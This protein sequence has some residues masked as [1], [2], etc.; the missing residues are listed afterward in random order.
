MPV[1]DVISWTTMMT[2]Y[3]PPFPPQSIIIFDKGL[4]Y[5]LYNQPTNTLALYRRMVNEGCLPNEFT[6][7]CLLIAC[8]ELKDLEMGKHLHEQLS[9]NLKWLEFDAIH[10]ALVTMY[11]TCGEVLTAEKVSFL[12]FRS[13]SFINIIDLVNISKDRI[14]KNPRSIAGWNSLIN[15]YCKTNQL[16]AAIS[17]L[18][19]I[20]RHRCTPNANTF[21][22]LFKSCADSQNLAVA[23]ESYE[24]FKNYRIPHSEFTATSA[25]SMFSKCKS[26]VNAEAVS[27]GFFFFFFSLQKTITHSCNYIH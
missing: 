18:N 2:T 22:P 26:I 11:L 6:Y 1:R 17:L 25:I 9:Q 4:K 3:P 20:D 5:N 13:K 16:K 21:L 12:S 8:S 19:Q 27:M 24:K 14:T 7:S 10:T 15:I 23:K